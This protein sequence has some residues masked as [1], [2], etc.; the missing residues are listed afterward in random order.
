MK[1][2]P[3]RIT[4]PLNTTK[5][6]E[7]VAADLGIPPAQVHET[8]MTVFDVI[9]RAAASGHKVAVTNF[10][11]WLPY[12]R[13]ARKARNPQTG[14]TFKA[15][16]YQAVRFRVSPTLADAV[17]RRLSASASIRKLPKGSGGR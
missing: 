4:E 14:E 2:K 1:K 15:A 13:K 11:T 9:T 10:G 3:T 16:S 7:T 8:V 12:R 17:R 5:L 6:I